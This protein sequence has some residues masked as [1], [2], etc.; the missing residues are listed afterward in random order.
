MASLGRASEVTGFIHR[1]KLLQTERRGLPKDDNKITTAL[2]YE[3]MPAA[4]RT[5]RTGLQS[6]LIEAGNG[7]LAEAEREATTF[8]PRA[9]YG[10]KDSTN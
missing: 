3:G 4:R 9:L 10:A 8:E 2:T 5:G 1:G 6:T 7:P